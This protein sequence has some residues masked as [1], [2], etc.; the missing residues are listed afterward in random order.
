[1]DALVPRVIKFCVTSDSAVSEPRTSA[2]AT[3]SFA[4]FVNGATFGAPE[5]D[6]RL[7]GCWSLYIGL[8]KDIKGTSNYH[9]HCLFGATITALTFAGF[10][11]LRP[12]VIN[13]SSAG[14]SA[15]LNPSTTRSATTDFAGF[16]ERAALWAC[17]KS[18]P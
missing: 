1:M 10:Y 5:I 18:D 9:S 17:R 7:C 14:T 6:N 16:L 11:A 8:I 15:V 4:R 2:T 12:S 3:T 13:V